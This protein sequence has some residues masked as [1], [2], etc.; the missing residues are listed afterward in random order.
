MVGQPE[1]IASTRSFG[2]YTKQYKH[3]SQT[4]GCE[5]KF[6]VFFPPDV[7][8]AP[9]LY[10]LSGLT[11]TDRNFIEKAGGQRKAAELGIAL[12]APDTS[13]R[14]LG[15]PGED[16]SYDFGTG[17][18]FYLNASVTAWKQYRMY[19]YITLELPSVLR[20]FPQLDV[21][22]ASITG[23]SMGGHGALVLGL[24]NPDLYRSISA[25]A[26]ISS[27]SLALWGQKAFKG[28]LGDDEEAW[29]EYDATALV[30]KG[31][32]GQ[33]AILIDVGTA[34]SNCANQLMPELFDEAAKKAGVKANTRMQDGYDHSYFFIA[35][36]VDDH[37]QHAAQALKN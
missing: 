14:G 16:D 5:M 17:A 9:I 12:V 25:F 35:S 11:C 32:T 20:S 30:T 15:V 37:V 22:R 21:D 13:P 23:H 31:Y 33:H 29:K 6:S 26:P 10:F 19:D 27:P 7:E 8:K 3:M 24:R 36:F 4:L 18:G 34:D 2:G 28:Y 1:E